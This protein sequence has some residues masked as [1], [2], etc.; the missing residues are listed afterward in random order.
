MRPR[1]IGSGNRA[2]L[3]SSEY[4]V[5]LIAIMIG[6]LHSK[7]GLYRRETLQKAL[8]SLLLVPQLFLIGYPLILT[9]TARSRVRTFGICIQIV[10]PPMP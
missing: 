9:G 3:L 10:L 2:S 8:D 7:D 5:N 6:V 4:M 1:L